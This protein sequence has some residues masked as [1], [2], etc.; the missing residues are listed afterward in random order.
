M[1]KSKVDTDIR[2]RHGG[3]TYAIIHIIQLAKA[4]SNQQAFSTHEYKGITTSNLQP[5]NDSSPFSVL[6]I[7]IYISIA[8]NINKGFFSLLA[9]SFFLLLSLTLASTTQLLTMQ[10]TIHVL[11]DPT[12]DVH[13]PAKTYYTTGNNA[14]GSISRLKTHKVT[15]DCTPIDILANSTTLLAIKNKSQG[16]PARKRRASYGKCFITDHMK[17]GNPKH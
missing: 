6:Y 16:L 2:S 8:S 5:I 9:L 17:K 10:S 7:Y 15:T 1:D 3:E 12:V 14:G 11:G 4:I 13:A